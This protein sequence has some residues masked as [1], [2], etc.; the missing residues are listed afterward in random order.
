M[1]PVAMMDSA[2]AAY[3]DHCCTDASG[4]QFTAVVPVKVHVLLGQ[5]WFYGESDVEV[6]LQLW[7]DRAR[8]RA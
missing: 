1:N 8:E 3:C 6:R 5:H 2:V 7:K 4:Q